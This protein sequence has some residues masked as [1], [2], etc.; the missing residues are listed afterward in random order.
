MEQIVIQISDKKK[1]Q[2]L[3]ELL[4]ALDFVDSIKTSEYVQVDENSSAQDEKM[5]FFSLAGLWQGRE[6]TQELIRKNSWPRQ[7]P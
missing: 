2:K 3:V 5:D 7:N 1:A 6:V 4:E